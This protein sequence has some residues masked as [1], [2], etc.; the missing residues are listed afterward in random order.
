MGHV[1]YFLLA[2]ITMSFINAPLVT[3]IALVVAV[4]L[5]LLNEVKNGLSLDFIMLTVIVLLSMLSKL[6]MSVNLIPM[7]YVNY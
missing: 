6:V 2:A 4:P 5:N 3:R 7:M 1:G